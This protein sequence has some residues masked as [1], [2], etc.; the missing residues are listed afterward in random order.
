MGPRSLKRGNTKAASQL[1]A[2]QAELQWGHA[3]SSVETR[4]P[5]SPACYATRGFNGA[6]LSQAWKPVWDELRK[7][8]QW[9][10]QWGHAISSVETFR[11]GTRGCG[12]TGASMGPRSLKRG[13]D[14]SIL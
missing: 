13:N 8:L 10:L 1:A 2:L 5:S 4:H 3:L 9:M 7:H 12:S 6:T 11:P 14:D